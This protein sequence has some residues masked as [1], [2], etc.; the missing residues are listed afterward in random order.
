LDEFVTQLFQRVLSRAPSD[1]ERR[2]FTEALFEGYADRV[3]ATPTGDTPKRP[4]VTKAVMWSNHLN[5]ESTTVVYE[6]EKIVR[7]GDPATMRL[8]EAWR[9]RAEDVVWTLMLTPEFAFVP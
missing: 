2:A 4:R 1:A 7:A 6:A 5:P 8:R 9:E 3:V